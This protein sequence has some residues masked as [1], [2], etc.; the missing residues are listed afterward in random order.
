MKGRE[1]GGIVI[2]AE[3]HNPLFSGLTHLTD[4]AFFLAAKIKKNF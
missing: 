3:T 2:F 4:E 1:T